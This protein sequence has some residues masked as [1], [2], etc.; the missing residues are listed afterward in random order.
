[1]SLFFAYYALLIVRKNTFDPTAV[2]FTAVAFVF[3]V[4]VLVTELKTLS[5]QMH[6]ND[7]GGPSSERTMSTEW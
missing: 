2:L 6:E 7:E 1:V 5:D 3:S 4:I